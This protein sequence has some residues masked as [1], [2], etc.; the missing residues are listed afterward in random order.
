MRKNKI[1]Y[2]ALAKDIGKVPSR[3]DSRECV[4]ALALHEASH[5]RAGISNG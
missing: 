2:D 5:P 3:D 1:Q 4:R